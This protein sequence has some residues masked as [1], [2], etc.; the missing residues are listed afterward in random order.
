[1]GTPN[2]SLW[3]EILAICASWHKAPETLEVFGVLRVFFILIKW[4][5]CESR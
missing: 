3:K 1:M 2:K 5:V 4:K